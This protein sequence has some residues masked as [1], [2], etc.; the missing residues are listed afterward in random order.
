MKC[1]SQLIERKHHKHRVQRSGCKVQR[2]GHKVQR[3][4]CKVQRSGHK[5]QRLGQ[6]SALVC[7][8]CSMQLTTRQ[9]SFST[10][11]PIHPFSSSYTL[12]LTLYPPYFPL[13]YVY[14]SHCIHTLAIEGMYCSNSNDILR[15]FYNNLYIRYNIMNAKCI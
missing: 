3:S 2:S 4:G 11:T 1:L 15:N 13:I 14:H 6:A 7:A 8:R 10:P 9:P 5:L 12:R